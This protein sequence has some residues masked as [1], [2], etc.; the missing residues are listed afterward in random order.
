M[1]LTLFWLLA[2]TAAPPS[3]TLGA[4]LPRSETAGLAISVEAGR[5]AGFGLGA[6]Y[7]HPLSVR[8]VTLSAQLSLGVSGATP[9]AP[10]GALHLAASYGHRHRGLLAAGWGAIGRSVLSLHGTEVADRS[11][12]GPDAGGG[13]EYISDRGLLFRA[14]LGAAYLSRAWQESL[15][16]FTTTVTV[17]FGWKIW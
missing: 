1:P 14:L 10:A 2:V 11:L 17:V 5:Y 7:Y 16:R 6:I 13:Y 8:P 3:T 9:R 15:P 4:A 12:F